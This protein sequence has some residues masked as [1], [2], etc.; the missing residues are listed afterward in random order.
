MIRVMTRNVKPFE[1]VR[2]E[3]TASISSQT[4]DRVWTEW[5]A[6]AYEEAEVKV[7][8]RYGELDVESGQVVDASAEDIPAGEVPVVT[9][10][11]TV[12]EGG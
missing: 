2:A 11:P 9:P 4:E 1:E 5:L 10:T 6:A 3:I 7:N 8:P 12:P